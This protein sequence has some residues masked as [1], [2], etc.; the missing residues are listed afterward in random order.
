MH[1]LP[2]HVVSCLCGLGVLFVVVDGMSML[3]MGRGEG[4]AAAKSLN[5]EAMRI[6]LTSILMVGVLL[7]PIIWDVALCTKTMTGSVRLVRRP[8]L[9]LGFAWPL[10]MLI[11]DLHYARNKLKDPTFF[12]ALN[13][14]GYLQTDANT[15]IT[16]AFKPL[17]ATSCTNALP[18]DQ[19]S[20][21]VMP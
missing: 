8:K 2:G 12:E 5:N 4:A 17:G 20:P 18:T 21:K 15:L 13:R 7:W 1:S 10:I 14:I 11:G 16:A 19:Y 3:N 6:Y 9:L